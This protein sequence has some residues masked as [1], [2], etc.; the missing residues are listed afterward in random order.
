MRKLRRYLNSAHL[1]F[2]NWF[3]QPV[4][5]EI[6][7]L[8][9]GNDA[10]CLN[11]IRSKAELRR[12]TRSTFQALIALRADPRVEFL[13]REGYLRINPG[14]GQPT[15]AE[16]SRK[17]ERLIEDPE[18]S[19]PRGWGNFSRSIIFVIDK[20]PEL[21]TL[22]TDE[23]K[24][25]LWGY[26]GTFFR[27]TRVTCWRNKHVPNYDARREVFSNFWHCDGYLPCRT[28]LF[29]NL[30]NVTLETGAFRLHPISSTKRIMRSGYFT[31][32]LVRGKARRLIDDPAYIVYAEG[33]VGSA[34]FCNTQLCLH[35]AGIPRAG[36]YRDIVEFT[37]EPS[38]VPLP[39]NWFEQ[40][41]PDPVEVCIMRERS[42]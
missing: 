14:Y 41:A 30:S 29:V 17:V 22:L 20:I 37:F 40:V 38:P 10:G 32:Y 19:I 36:S 24:E 8:I 35:A 21:G 4:L 6:P 33:A 15:L 16:I 9:Y 13:K 3:V 28:K 2:L 39:E 26:Y 5:G 12:L 7:R 1:R 42:V 34:I 25:L 18:H 11:N 23:I 27:V 31:R